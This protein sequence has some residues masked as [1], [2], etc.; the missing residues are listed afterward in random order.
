MTFQQPKVQATLFYMPWALR[1]F[2][3]CG[4]LHFVTFS[5]YHR[6]PRLAAPAARVVLEKVLERMRRK[7]GFYVCGYVVMPEHIHILMSEP[8]RETLATALQAVKQAVSKRLGT[9]D[10]GAFWQERYY[11]F[12]VFSASKLTE[13]LRYMHRNPVKRG[14]VQQPEEWRWSSF[15]HYLYGEE[16]NV[17]IESKW[18]A[19]KRERAGEVLTVKSTTPP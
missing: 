18:T 13:K 19:K 5:C 12:N 1:R 2:Q 6:R 16:G 8:E 15:R 11:D 14:L 4:Q 17:E 10:G 7:Y 3:Q 9:G